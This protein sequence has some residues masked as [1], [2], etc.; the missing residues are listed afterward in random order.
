MKWVLIHFFLFLV[1]GDVEN[2][3]AVESSAGADSEV[4]AKL[5]KVLLC[6]LL[7]FC[8]YCVKVW[9]IFWK[10]WLTILFV[11]IFRI[12]YIGVIIC[13]WNFRDIW[14]CFCKWKNRA[15]CFHLIHPLPFFA[16]FCSLASF[17]YLFVFMCRI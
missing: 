17:F 14:R 13:F 6:C 2:D 15:K 12:L 10:L 5:M 16:T 4:V 1:G 11:D 7:T 9:V 3:G 8:N